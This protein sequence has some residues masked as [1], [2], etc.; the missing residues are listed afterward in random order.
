MAAGAI[1]P[2]AVTSAQTEVA[3]TGPREV[4]SARMGA[5][6]TGSLE[7]DMSPRTGAEGTGVLATRR[8]VAAVYPSWENKTRPPLGDPYRFDTAR[9]I[10]AHR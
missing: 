8:G 5:A 4:M 1:G 2:R 10:A 3:A 9:P 7:E 6:V